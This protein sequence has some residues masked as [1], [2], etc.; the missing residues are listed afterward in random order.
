MYLNL[1]DRM[2]R[3]EIN[4]LRVAN[5]TYIRLQ[6]EIVYLAVILDGFSRRVVRWELDRTLAVRLPLTELEQAI[7]ERKPGPGLVHHA[8][9]GL[10]YA[11]TEYVAAP[12]KQ[13]MIPSMSRPANPYDNA[14]CESSIKTLKREEI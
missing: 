2:N 3:T 6:R 11:S 8:D 14:S 12:R 4:Q 5:I 7:A 13:Q 10:Q 9:R 1:A